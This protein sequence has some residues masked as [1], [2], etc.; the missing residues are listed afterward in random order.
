MIASSFQGTFSW[1]LFIVFLVFFAPW[2]WQT[3]QSLKIV[4]TYQ[5]TTGVIQSADYVPPDASQIV[6][7]RALSSVGTYTH[8]AIFTTA[9]GRQGQAFTRVR[10]NPPAFEIGDT[11][12]VYHHP[13]DLTKA[14]IG[15]FWELWLAPIALGF[16]T[17]IFFFLWLGALV[18]DPAPITQPSA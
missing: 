18:G 3:S 15:T 8:Q 5:V 10:S 2:C 6:R 4:L 13:T 7:E 14:R 16:F 11:V 9:D 1:P 17:A 12:K